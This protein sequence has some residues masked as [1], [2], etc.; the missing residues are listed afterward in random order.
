MGSSR[1][2][3]FAALALLAGL[4]GCTDN[5]VPAFES[6][7]APYLIPGSSTCVAEGLPP[8]SYI[9]SGAA[10]VYILD[11]ATRSLVNTSEVPANNSGSFFIVDPTEKA[12]VVKNAAEPTQ[13]VVLASPIDPSHR[14][15]I[16]VLRANATTQP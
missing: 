16:W 4:C 8:L 10:T 6:G 7:K 12:V 11:D 3:P 14:F 5:S 15:S 13:R 9:P 2:L 1:L